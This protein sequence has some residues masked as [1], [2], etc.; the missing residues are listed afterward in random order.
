MAIKRYEN[1][2]VNTLTFGTDAYGEYTTTITCDEASPESMV[3]VV[4]NPDPTKFHR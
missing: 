4:L 1:V 3:A 2:D